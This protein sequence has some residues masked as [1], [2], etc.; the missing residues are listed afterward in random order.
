MGYA[1]TTGVIIYWKP[2][3]PFVVHRAHHIWFDEYS[4]CFSIEENHTPGY[5]LLKQYPEII[6]HHSE[7]LNLIPFELDIIS[8]PF[9]GTIILT[10][11]VE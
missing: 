3:Q 10:Y 4:Y 7:L 6:L 8:T 1:S 9:C 5:L 2:D 11:E